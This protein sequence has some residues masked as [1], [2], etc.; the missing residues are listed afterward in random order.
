MTNLSFRLSAGLFSVSAIALS[1]AIGMPEAHAQTVIDNQT[2]TVPPDTIPANTVL[3]VGDTGAGTLNIVT[4]GIVTTNSTTLG[5]SAGSS[6][7]IS[8]SGAGASFST[9]NIFDIGREG[10][11]TFTITNGATATSGGASIGQLG[12]TGTVT[13]SGAGSTWTSTGS[14]TVGGDNGS[15]ATL[16]VLDG[17]TLDLGTNT[18][19][20]SDDDSTA[21]FNA[22]GGSTITSGDAIF[23]YYSDVGVGVA[24]ISG[25]GTTWSI[26]GELVLGGEGG[27]GELN[28]LAGAVVT[29]TGDLTMG[30]YDEGVTR[31]DLLVSGTG[32]RL[33][34]AG[35]AVI[36]ADRPAIAII[37]NGGTMDVTGDTTISDDT[38]APATLTVT[39]Q[40]SRYETAGLTVGAY[41]EGNLN[42]LDLG[43]L[44]SGTAIVGYRSSAVGTVTVDNGFWMMNGVPL[45]VGES[46]TGTVTV[47]NG[48][49]IGSAS[50]RPT[51][52]TLGNL[53]GSSGTMT[54]T[55]AGSQAVFSAQAWVGKSGTGSLSVL[56][57][58]YIGAQDIFV[59]TDAGSTG[60]LLVDGA[61]SH[62]LGTDYISIGNLSAGSATVSNGGWLESA[63]DMTIAFQAPGTVVVTGQGSRLTTVGILRVGHFGNGSLTISDGGKVIVDEGDSDTVVAMSAGSNGNL[64]VTGTGSE[65]DTYDLIIGQAGTGT[66][67]VSNGG[68]ITAHSVTIGDTGTGTLNIG[69]APGSAPAAAG[70]INA[71]TVE[72]HSGI[73]TL[74][75]NLLGATTF[76][77]QLIGNGEMNVLAG[78]TT[79][80]TNSPSYAGAVNV[81]GGMAVVN[82]NLPGNFTV[83]DT[84]I[85]GGSGTIGSLLMQAGGTVAP[86]N[87]PGTLNVLGTTTFNAGSNYNVEVAGALSDLINTTDAVLNGGTVH[88]SGAPSLMRYTILTSA[89]T[90]TG[91]GF[92][93]VDTTSAFINYGLE[94]DPNNVYLVIN[95]V[96]SL[97]TAALTPNE[98]AAARALDQ[99]GLGNPLYSLIVG[100]NMSDAR[101]AMNALSG[102]VHASVGS[103][104]A[105]NNRYVREAVMGRMV[106][107]QNNRAGGGQAVA[108][109][110][111]GPQNVAEI[112]TS[113]RMSLGAGPGSTKDALPA[114]GHRL[115]YWSHAVGAWGKYESDN[116]AAS[117]DRDLGGFI[118][119]IDGSLGGGWRAGLVGGY[120]YTGLS[121]DNR[122]SK[123]QADS[124]VLGGYAGGDL[125]RGFALR[126]GGTWTWSDIDTSRNVVFPGFFEHQKADYNANVAQVF[127][128]LAYPIMSRNIALEPFAGLAY[129]HVDTGGFTESGPIAG[130]TSEGQDTDVGYGTVGLRI[131]GMWGWGSSRIQPHASIAWQYAFGDTTPNQLLQFSSNG[132]GMD[133]RGVPMAQNSALLDVGADI[134]LSPDATLSISYT[135]QY[136]GDFNDNGVRGRFNWKF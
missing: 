116:N 70:V 52:L 10:T 22:S 71:P 64:H 51:T 66:A 20:I 114:G 80:V 2:V 111:A 61:G 130:L 89:N 16:N 35:N 129:V 29:A 26:D 134:M 107:A 115:A 19:Y 36:G 113:S 45:T 78:T 12:G 121:V 122:L 18:I 128:E 3:R 63:D 117:A 90:W 43:S 105:D 57:G 7:T 108:L 37:S 102:E 120:V 47:R 14:M 54:I 60:T 42:I 34:I 106:Q 123:A 13:V 48:G 74:N 82:A 27:S 69:A 56:D 73:G 53:A 76:S 124:Y 103:A 87:S 91:G 4:G 68:M 101:Q 83:S 100:G 28:I 96:N 127:A 94:Y 86:G 93:G 119:G 23:G 21:T 126:S 24:N 135:G 77:P 44:V 67:T 136:S 17:A 92:A 38:T 133:I 85:V 5:F 46:G 55:G 81:T 131:G 8:V 40:G 99:F 75:F 65:L 132:I 98:L 95:G 25:A 49:Q 11:G 72:L 41:G 110:S 125:G 109:A 84:G 62:A 79:F 59:G 15:I 97:T 118:T 30:E 39:G 58:G 31:G 88:A 32:S 33:S 104:L 50:V 1:A 9:A 112:D 6:G